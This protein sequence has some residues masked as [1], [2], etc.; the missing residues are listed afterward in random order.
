MCVNLL[1]LLPNN[2]ERDYSYLNIFLKVFTCFIHY[3]SRKIRY[4]IH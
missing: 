1:T 2:V 3:M 4:Y